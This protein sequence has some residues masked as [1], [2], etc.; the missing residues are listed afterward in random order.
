MLVGRRWLVG[1]VA[2]LV[3]LAAL[4]LWRRR[5]L[6]TQFCARV[7]VR[8]KILFL[9]KWIQRFVCGSL[10]GKRGGPV[11]KAP[12]CVLSTV[13]TADRILRRKPSDGARLPCMATLLLALA[14]LARQDSCGGIC[15]SHGRCTLGVCVCAPGFAGPDCSQLACKNDCHRQGDCVDGLCAC[16]AGFTG[17]LDQTAPAHAPPHPSA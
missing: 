9:L 10:Q 5:K 13:L 2:A 11:W 12:S 4:G 17:T 6:R 15:S 1:I 14:A 3:P 8:G 16:Y 7:C